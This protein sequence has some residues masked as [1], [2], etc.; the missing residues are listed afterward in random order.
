MA[1]ANFIYADGHA[2]WLKEP[3]LDCSAWVAILPSGMSVLTA[4]VCRPAGQ[5]ESWCNY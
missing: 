2:K 3:P 1:G 4:G 5:G